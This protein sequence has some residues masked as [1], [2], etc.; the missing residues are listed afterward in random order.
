LWFGLALAPPGVVAQSD[1]CTTGQ[2]TRSE[3]YAD[4]IATRMFYTVYTPPC[5]EQTDERYPVLYLLHGSNEDDNHWLRLGLQDVLDAGITDGSLPPMIVVMPFGNWIANENRF[6]DDSWAGVFINQ[7]MPLV[8][9]D[10]RVNGN[11]ATRAIGGISRGGFWAYHIALKHPVLFGAVGGHSAFFDRYH[12]EPDDNPLDLALNAPGVDNMRLWLDRGADDYA[13]PGLE[14]MNE[15]LIQRGVDFSYTVYPEGQHNNTYWRQHIRT[16]L[17][18]YTSGWPIPTQAQPEATPEP[19]AAQAVS[20]PMML[21]LPV[22]AFPSLEANL[23]LDMLN[24]IRGGFL[25]D[26]LILSESN[27]A[28]LQ[29]HGVTVPAGTRIVPDDTLYNQMWRDTRLF[30]LM[31]FDQLTPRYRVLRVDEIHPLDALDGYPFAF[32]SDT[33]NF[34]PARLTR[35]LM[36]GV[37]ALT[38]QTIPPLDEN[39]VEWAASGILPYVQ[40]ADFFHTSNEVS[41]VP[42]CP[43]PAI[44]SLA[45]AGFS[46]CSKVE[47]FELFNRLGLDIVELSGNHNNDFGYDAYRETLAWY[48]QNDIATVGGGETTAEAQMPLLIEHNDNSIALVSCNWVGPF[49]ALVNEDPDLAG[50]VRPGAASC[51][52]EWLGELL[53]QLQAD[54]DLVVVTVQYQEFD[55]YTPTNQQRVDFRSLADLGADVVMGTQ[56]HFPQ[57]FEFYAPSAEREAFIHYGLGNLFFDQTFFAGERFFMDQLFIYDGRLLTVDLFTGLIE[58]QGRPRPMTSDERLNFLFLILSQ[59]G[60]W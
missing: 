51:D 55:E 57:I 9:A 14:I 3:Y 45:G 16:Y 27:A 49:Y 13:A 36:S 1:D 44:T 59:Y 53:P 6:D 40:A 54:H 32:E 10:Y 52:R 17:D 31:P 33:P 23:P 19:E 4:V 12:A 37:T 34:D 56:A 25:V 39:G 15:H 21:F 26:T 18:F 48:Q 5:Y 28:S 35:L 30:T 24:T 38:R 20:G 50:G 43:T 22:V 58:D 29:A 42:G 2:T 11:R 47:H 8:E 7:L 60:S 41:I 46:F